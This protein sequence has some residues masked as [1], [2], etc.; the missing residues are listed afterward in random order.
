M[1]LLYTKRK[2]LIWG[3]TYP[4]LS[5]RY[6]ETVCTGASGE[7]GRPIRIYPVRLRYL[8]EH[9]R[10]KLFD[11]VEVPMSKSNKDHR[12]ESFRVDGE[13]LQIC[14][15]IETDH[16]WLERRKIIFADTT[17]HYE[18]VRDLV[19]AER[20]SK[21]SMGMVK[22]GAVDGVRLDYKTAEERKQHEE[23]ATRI[24]SKT[25][26]FGFTP[27]DLDFYPYRIYVRWRCTRLEGSNACPGHENLILDWGLGELGRRLGGEAAR[28][29]MEALCDLQRHDLRFFMGNFK[30]HPHNFGV[31]A[32]WYPLHRDIERYPLIQGD[33]FSQFG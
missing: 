26:L 5:A 10:Y 30:A 25:D 14:G 21:T 6:D 24:K 3:K 33:L 16:G 23:K 22:V 11:W 27:K 28:A 31:V 19:Q 20:R 17:W 8:Q 18:C 4:E 32:L 2:V 13:K 15:H 9:Q 7:D 29:K 1:S 12:P